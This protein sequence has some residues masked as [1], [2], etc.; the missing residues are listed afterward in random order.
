MLIVLERV[1]AIA[2]ALT[3][4]VRQHHTP[5]ECVRTSAFV[6]RIVFQYTAQ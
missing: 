2:P 4:T 6:G 1:L 3:E 5:S